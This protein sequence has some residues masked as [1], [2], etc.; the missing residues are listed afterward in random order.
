MNYRELQLITIAMAILAV[1]VLTAIY[2]PRVRALTTINTSTTTYVTTTVMETSTSTVYTTT[3]T[4]TTTSTDTTP[5]TVTSTVTGTEYL[6]ESTT[7]VTFV[8]TSVYTTMTIT[9]YFNTTVVE[10]E[11]TQTVLYDMSYNF[12]IA[13]TTYVVTSSTAYIIMSRTISLSGFYT[14]CVT[15][16]VVATNTVRVNV[17]STTTVTVTNNVTQHT[18]FIK[19]LQKMDITFSVNGT[20]TL[21]T[22]YLMKETV[23]AIGQVSKAISIVTSTSYVTLTNFYNITYIGGTVSTTMY[24]SMSTTTV[25]F[26][27]LTML[28]TYSTSYITNGTVT[29]TSTVVPMVRGFT[30]NVSGAFMSG[31]YYISVGPQA[32]ANVFYLNPSTAVALLG[33]YT[34]VNA[35]MYVVYNGTTLATVTAGEVST[36]YSAPPNVTAY[37]TAPSY[38]GTF[39]VYDANVSPISYL[40]DYEDLAYMAFV[41]GVGLLSNLFFRGNRLHAIIGMISV[42]IL[43]GIIGYAFGIPLAYTSMATVVLVISA[44]VLA[45]VEKN[46]ET[47][48]DE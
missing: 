16:T 33:N 21:T 34:P 27:K 14:V 2:L 44:A 25:V 6:Y 23:V 35:T 28:T 29:V 36:I 31:A 30:M 42:A 8:A 32:Y 46:R 38:T 47:V 4:V 10:Y 5:T 9:Q 17:A 48:I 7:S 39:V 12:T 19:N 43:G 26:T 24:I 13:N 18:V 3:T 1:T 22:T 15:P 41:I 20:A 40:S 45:I 11:S 37:V